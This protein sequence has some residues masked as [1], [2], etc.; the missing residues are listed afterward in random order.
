[1]TEQITSIPVF[2]SEVAP[3]D[4]E[5]AINQARGETTNE[6]ELRNRAAEAAAEVVEEAKA[7]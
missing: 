6:V 1:M 2:D 7:E 4:R 3:Q 5:R